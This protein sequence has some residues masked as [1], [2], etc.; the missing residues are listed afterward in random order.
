MAITA[1]EADFFLNEIDIPE[2]QTIDAH[3]VTFSQ[4]AGLKKEMSMP[5]FII[6]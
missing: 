6:S 4:M 1:V 2:L 5:R 3:R